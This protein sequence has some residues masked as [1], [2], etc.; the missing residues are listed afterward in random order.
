MTALHWAATF[1]HKEMVA[2]LLEQMKKNPDLIAQVNSRDDG[3]RTPL[4][5]AAENGHA[6]V[7]QLLLDFKADVDSKDHERRTPLSYAAENGHADV[8]KLLLGA[9]PR[10]ADVNSESN[11]GRTPLGWAKANRHEAVVTLLQSTGNG[12][13]ADDV[14]NDD[15]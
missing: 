4:S 15:H 10:G 7:V 8:A 6:D 5:Y 9:K 1:R 12:E 2:L 11:S 13:G 14:E 3:G